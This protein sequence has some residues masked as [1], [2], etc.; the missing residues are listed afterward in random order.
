MSRGE[1]RPMT[2]WF[3]VLFALAQA[4]DPQTTAHQ[5]VDDFR[6][7]KYAEARNEFRA[8]LKYAPQNAGLWAYLGLTEG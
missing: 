5:A 8:A 6:A 7:S 2:G 1:G 4:V 3:I